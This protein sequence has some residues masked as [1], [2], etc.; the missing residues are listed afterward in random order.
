MGLKDLSLVTM[1][2]GH[3]I[4]LQSYLSSS[5]FQQEV[6]LIFLLYVFYIHVSVCTMC[7]P[8]T[9]RNQRKDIKYFDTG[10]ISRQLGA[11]MWLQRNQPRSSAEAVGSLNHGG[12]L[13][14]THSYIFAAYR[15]GINSCFWF[16]SCCDWNTTTKSTYRHKIY[17]VLEFQRDKE[18]IVTVMAANCS[19]RNRSRI[20]NIH[21]LKTGTKKRGQ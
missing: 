15:L 21:I 12:K 13:A 20:L 1:L 19:H 5:V 16:M 4:Y 17:C 6:Y 8:D 10:T 2:A 14:L 9:W 3:G 11:S 18:S 7:V